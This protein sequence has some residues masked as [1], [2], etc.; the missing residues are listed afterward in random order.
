MEKDSKTNYGNLSDC[1]DIEQY[2]TLLICKK[3]ETSEYKLKCY[4][5][6]TQDIVYPRYIRFYLIYQYTKLSYRIIAHHYGTNEGVVCR[7][8]S[9]I[10]NLS[11]K[12]KSDIILLQKIHHLLAQIDEK[13]LTYKK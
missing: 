10:N 12:I 11:D 1:N 13:F 8:I 6:K 7:S 9:K 2:I 4:K 5:I 3:F